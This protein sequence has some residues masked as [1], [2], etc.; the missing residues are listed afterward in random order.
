MVSRYHPSNEI[1]AYFQRWI[2][3]CFPEKYVPCTFPRNLIDER[4]RAESEDS[5][6]VHAIART[7]RRSVSV[8]SSRCP[9]TLNLPRRRRQLEEITSSNFRLL[10]RLERAKS[11]YTAEEFEREYYRKVNYSLISSF[12]LRKRCQAIISGVRSR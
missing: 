10:S 1:F 11:E 7:M 6:M 8:G 5:K 4:K 12:S 2:A 9:G 3:L